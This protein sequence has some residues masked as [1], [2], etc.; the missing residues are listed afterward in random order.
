MSPIGL[1][2]LKTIGVSVLAAFGVVGGWRCSRWRYPWWLA[3]YVAPLAIVALIGLSRWFLWLELRPPFRWVM[4]GRTEFAL[5][6]PVF[7]LLLTNLLLRLRRTREKVLLAI[8]MVA[9]VISQSVLAFLLPALQY[10]RLS[11][12]K[13][14]V[15]VNGVCIQSNGYTCGPAATVTALRE[16]GVHAHEGELSVLAH[17]TPTTGTQPDVLCQAIHQR[18]AVPC[19]QAFFRNISELRPCVPVVAVV[20]F[21]FLTDHF[22]TVL[23]VT[24]TAVVIGDPLTGR[25]EM[26]HE[27]FAKRWR[28][29][30]IVFDRLP[31][32]LAHPSP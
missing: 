20:K 6:A 15:D 18:Y 10:H 32:D 25:V 5:L 17:T 29:C 12:L 13:T 27:A 26:T 11:A 23:D 8:L 24:D 1:A 28:R 21:S 30:G 3:G 19:R 22:V 16:I 7:T 2:W 9:A 4:A 14:F 31:T